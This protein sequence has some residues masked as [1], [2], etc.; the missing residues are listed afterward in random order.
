MYYFDGLELRE[1]AEYKGC[2]IAIYPYEG[3]NLT[4]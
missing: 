4:K 1:I 3:D 2:L